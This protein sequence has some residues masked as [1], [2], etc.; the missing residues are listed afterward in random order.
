MEL[1]FNIAQSWNG[2]LELCNG[3]RRTP[4]TLKQ[5][6]DLGLQVSSLEGFELPAYQ[7]AYQFGDLAYVDFPAPR[8]KRDEF[9]REL[10]DEYRAKPATP[11]RNGV[12]R[13]LKEMLDELPHGAL[14]WQRKLVGHISKT[15]GAGEKL[16]YLSLDTGGGE[17][18][19]EVYSPE[20]REFLDQ[21]EDQERHRRYDMG[22]NTDLVASVS[23]TVLDSLEWLV[24]WNEA[25]PAVWTLLDKETY[26][27]C[28]AVHEAERVYEFVQI[29]QYPG[30][31]GEES[32][33]KR[34]GDLVC[35][36]DHTPEMILKLLIDNGYNGMN[37]P[38][39]KMRGQVQWQHI[40]ELIFCSQARSP[41]S[42]FKGELSF[43]D[44]KVW[45]RKETGLDLSE[46]EA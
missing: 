1:S 31:S 17:I 39:I 37:D 3:G 42:E 26:R 21:R 33:Y 45:I 29:N 19:L 18:L 2:K 4:L 34:S 7:K 40:A 38:R 28:R 11:R 27:C 43:E 41:Q 36:K 46:V 16:N 13:L 32:R 35:V 6:S 8:V 14:G 10:L 20:V 24:P 9:L 22:L 12:L 44:A 23:G 5:I 15:Y 30:D 25:S